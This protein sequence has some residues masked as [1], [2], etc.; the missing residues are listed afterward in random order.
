[1]ESNRIPLFFL[2][3]CGSIVLKNIL[4][5]KLCHHFLLLHVACRIFCSDELALTHNTIA[6]KYLEKIVLALPHLYEP[7]SQVINMHNLLHVADDAKSFNC[8]LSRISCFPF[9][10]V[11]G[12]IKRTIRTPNKSLSQIC[13]RLGEKD[14]FV[15]KVISDSSN[16][17]LK[18]VVRDS[19][20][21]IKQIRWNLMTIATNKGNNMVLLKNNTIMKIKSIYCDKDD[22]SLSNII[23]EGEIWKKRKLLYTYSCKSMLLKT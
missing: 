6:K 14:M 19:K 2:L 13:R 7:K 23:I 5:L 1:M 12:E 21:Y 9:E 8:S 11:L 22:D 20:I 18:K 10:S 15:K 16:K 4:S 17:I 3:Y